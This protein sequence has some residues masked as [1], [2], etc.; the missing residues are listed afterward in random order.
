MVV[1]DKHTWDE[2][3]NVDVCEAHHERKFFFIF[4]G[5]YC[6]HIWL[7]A[8]FIYLFI[9]FLVC[10][11][12][13]LDRKLCNAEI[14]FKLNSKDPVLL[15]ENQHPWAGMGFRYIGSENGWCPSVGM[16]GAEDDLQQ[17]MFLGFCKV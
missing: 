12:F 17:Q 5:L 11:A 10:V 7:L 2:N 3:F 8:L 13:L 16:T 14:R 15:V 6:K 4:I 1:R 9:S